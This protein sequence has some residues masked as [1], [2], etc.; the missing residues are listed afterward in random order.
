VSVK[1]TKASVSLS[2]VELDMVELTYK[3]L[4]VDAD[5]L[6]FAKELRVGFDAESR[7]RD[8]RDRPSPFGLG[9]LRATVGWP[10]WAHELFREVALPKPG[11]A[12]YVAELP[13]ARSMLGAGRVLRKWSGP[14]PRRALADGDG[15]VA[16]I[17]VGEGR[18][19]E[20]TCDNDGETFAL[21]A[22]ARDG[23]SV[24]EVTNYPSDLD[25]IVDFLA[26]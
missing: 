18:H 3:N 4:G 20:L 26:H 11:V 7:L 6:E 5:L 19:V 24:V 10:A 25:V 2:V 16:L 1:S 14:Q 15:G 21:L 13:N 17:W 8:L 22:H 9:M 23:R 12:E